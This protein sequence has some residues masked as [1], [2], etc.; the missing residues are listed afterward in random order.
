MI[1][2][3]GFSAVLPVLHQRDALPAP[4]PE[5]E[6]LPHHWAAASTWAQP[7]NRT[8]ATAMKAFIRIPPEIS[9]QSKYM[10]RNSNHFNA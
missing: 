3:L 4:P 5:E 10:Y 8:V 9:S 2:A 6:E 7:M 1:S